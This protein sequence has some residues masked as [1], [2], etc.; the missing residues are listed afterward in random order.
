MDLL[1]RFVCYTYVTYV[2]LPES[3]KCK[4]VVIKVE[5]VSIEHQVDYPN[6]E[7]SNHS[8]HQKDAKAL[9]KHDETMK[10]PNEGKLVQQFILLSSRT[11]HPRFKV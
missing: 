2:I 10:N 9:L 8:K 4:Y 7:G 5:A 3:K 11:I 6:D 1:T